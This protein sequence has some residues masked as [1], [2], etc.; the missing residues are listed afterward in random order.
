M[1]ASLRG[2]GRPHPRSYLRAAKI[3]ATAAQPDCSLPTQ[4]HG[5]VQQT[6]S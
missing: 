5:E 4:L 2:Q 6:H 3:P 1:Q